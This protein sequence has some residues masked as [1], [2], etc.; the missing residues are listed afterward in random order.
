MKSVF[1]ENLNPL[2]GIFEQ[3]KQEILQGEFGCWGC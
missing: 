3:I 2:E 1:E